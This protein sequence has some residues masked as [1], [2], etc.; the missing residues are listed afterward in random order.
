MDIENWN[1]SSGGITIG[2]CW[3][4]SSTQRMLSYL[5]RYNQP[6]KMSQA[7]RRELVLNMV[8]RGVPTVQV[9]SSAPEKGNRQQNSDRV[10]TKDLKSYSVFPVEGNSVSATY[11]FWWDLRAGYDMSLSKKFT[12]KRSLRDDVQV[13]QGSHFFRFGNVGMGLGSGATSAKENYESLKTLMRN[14]DGKRLTLINLR[15]ERTNQHVVMVKS[16]RKT[17]SGNVVFT[18]YDSNQPLRDQEVTYYAKSGVFDSAGVAKYFGLAAKP[19]GV[20]IVDEEEREAFEV[21]MLNHYRSA[22]K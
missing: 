15:L 10:I 9:E 14:A 6:N 5:A 8:R 4:L 22:C 17:A 21:A 16:Y 2:N 20:F 3:A 11:D 7:A 12:V 18:V 13:N 19:M 1:F